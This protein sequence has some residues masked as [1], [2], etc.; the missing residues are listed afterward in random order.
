M[1]DPKIAAGAPGAAGGAEA[2]LVLATWFSPSYPVGAY[3]Y[4]HGLEWAV[5]SGAVTGRATAETWVRGCLAQGAGWTDAVLLARGMDAAQAGD[6]A[7]FDGLAALAEALAPARERHLE[8]MAQGAAFARVTGAVWPEAGS[9]P[10]AYP[11]AVARAAAARGLPP[12][13]VLGFF[14][15]GFAANLVSAAVRLVPLGQTDGQRILAALLPLCEELAERALSAG[16][17][18][19]GGCTLLADIAAMRHETQYS[20]LFRS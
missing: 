17:E 20:R 6:D 18:E 14:L 2:A 19:I 5:E 13:L 7:P 3:S 11:L 4:S 12:R 9:A 15:H 10:L 16:E 8:T 1:T